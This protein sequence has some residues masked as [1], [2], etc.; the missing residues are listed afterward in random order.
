MTVKSGQAIAAGFATVGATG[1]LT[2]ATG[3]PVGALYVAGVANGAAVT[4]AGANPYSW[5][6]TLPA[7]TAGQ[8]VQMYVTATIS[9]VAT[10]G[11][12]WDDVAD[13]ALNSDPV[14]LA[15]TQPAITWAAQTITSAA[16][17]AL[18]ISSTGGNGDGLQIS[19]NG[20]GA[21]V[22]ID[23]GATGIGVD[24]DAAAN[25][26]VSIA[27]N[28]TGRGALDTVNSHTDGHGQY[29][30][31]GATNNA[32][33]LK[34]EAQ[35]GQFN[36]GTL[37]GLE[38]NAFTGSFGMY[39]VGGTG[40]ENEG[41]TGYGEYSIGAGA[42]I[43]AEGGTGPGIQVDSTSVTNQ[44]AIAVQA[45]GNGPAIRLL[46]SGN[47]GLQVTGTTAD[48]NAD[49]TGNLSGSVGSVTDASTIAAAVWTYATRTLTSLSALVA[50]VAAAVWAY[51]TRTLTQSAAAVTAV[52]TGSDITITR[53]DTTSISLTDLGNITGYKA[54]WFSVKNGTDDAD[55]SSVVMV[56]TGTG[57][58]YLN[59]SGTV[60]ATDATLTVDDATTGD[61]TVTLKAALT[62]AL[63]ARGGMAYDVQWQDATD[64]IH[65]LTTGACDVSADVTRAVS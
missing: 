38:N 10:G 44:A 41:R 65:T 51:A 48:I 28:I 31:G 54:V 14:T 16:G 30:K 7:L 13:T 19:G 29:N 9:G 57:L 61:I 4:I 2:A 33:G 8:L 55:A 22:D 12:V 40:V 43:L 45:Y 11:F 42:G 32:S 20:T 6:V 35:I 36:V 60:T 37:V 39:N 24:I 63:A 26:G 59:G 62:A 52:V 34:N 53:G 1:T 5:S 58:V 27:G 3:T 46:A 64:G 23:A 50:S 21:G 18:T 49:I 25:M 56:K 47:D 17:N 15:A